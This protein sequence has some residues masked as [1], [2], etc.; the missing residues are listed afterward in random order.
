MYK[1]IIYNKKELELGIRKE[2]EEHGMSREQAT[3][4]AKDHLKENPH[5]YTLADKAGL[6]DEYVSEASQIQRPFTKKAKGIHGRRLPKDNPKRPSTTVG[7][8]QIGPTG[9]GGGY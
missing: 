6:E 8:S 3:K 4:T 9:A 2:T 5:Y 7:S 1:L